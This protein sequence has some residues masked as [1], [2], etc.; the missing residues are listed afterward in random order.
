MGSN[1][2][3]RL[4]A[5]RPRCKPALARPATRLQHPSSQVHLREDVV[6]DVAADVARHVP[7][8]EYQV[9]VV[10]VEVDDVAGAAGVLQTSCESSEHAVAERVWVVV[11]VDHDN[12]HQNLLADWRRYSAPALARQDFRDGKR[13]PVRRLHVLLKDIEES[14]SVDADSGDVAEHPLRWGSCPACG[15]AAAPSRCCAVSGDGVRERRHPDEQPSEQ[16][17]SRHEPIVTR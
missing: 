14:A 11:R 6:R 8:S 4:A 12:L 2:G 15:R 13:P 5:Y 17:Q 3:L 7:V 9:E 16:R 1:L 10:G